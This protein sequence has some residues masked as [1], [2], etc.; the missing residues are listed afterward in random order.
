M[1]NESTAVTAST[2][3]ALLPTLA[4]VVLIVWLVKLAMRSK[5]GGPNVPLLIDLAAMRD[6]MVA[7][8]DRGLW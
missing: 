6:A 2:I 8:E 4:G 1:I 7:A 5:N 3:V